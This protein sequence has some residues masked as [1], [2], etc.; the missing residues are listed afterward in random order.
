MQASTVFARFKIQKRQK[1]KLVP[2]KLALNYDARVMPPE[3][4][5][6]VQSSILRPRNRDPDI[7]HLYFSICGIRTYN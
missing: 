6:A 7:L 1:K 5:Q 2:A 4:D 3:L